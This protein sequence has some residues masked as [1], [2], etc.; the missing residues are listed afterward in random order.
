MVRY[1]VPAIAQSNYG[2]DGI[3]IHWVCCIDATQKYVCI[4]EEWHLTSVSINALS[5]NSFI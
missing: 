1:K 3:R 4:Y 5:A 2:I